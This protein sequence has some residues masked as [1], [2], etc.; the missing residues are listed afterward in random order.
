MILV[1]AVVIIAYLRTADANLLALF[2]SLPSAICG[3]TR[4][5]VLH[6]A[7]GLTDRQRLLVL[8]NAFHQVGD[9]P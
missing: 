9:L 6:G 1:D 7:R 4:A 2:R 3:V 5:E 8:L